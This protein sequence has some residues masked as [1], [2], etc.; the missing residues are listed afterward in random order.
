MICKIIHTTK[1][2]RKNNFWLKNLTNN[3]KTKEDAE[4]IL[5]RYDE[6]KQENLYQ[7]M[8]D[9]I[10]KANLEL[11]EEVDDMCDAL[12]EIV[13]PKVEAKVQAAREEVKAELIRKKLAKGMSFEDI[14]DFLEEPVE[15]IKSLIGS[16]NC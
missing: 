11:F 16:Q 10:V 1:L 14:A 13:K 5:K 2:S 9:I 3:L 6:R 7:S 4:S 12:M 15:T 8:M